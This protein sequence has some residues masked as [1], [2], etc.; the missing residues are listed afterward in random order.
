MKTNIY[1]KRFGFYLGLDNEKNP[2]V[3]IFFGTP[4][5]YIASNGGLKKA[6]T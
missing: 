1:I 3:W 6:G 4:L 5:P 2:N